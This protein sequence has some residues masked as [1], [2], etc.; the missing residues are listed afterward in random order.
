MRK[1]YKWQNVY[2]LKNE[3][4]FLILTLTKLGGQMIIKTDAC[5]KRVGQMLLKKWERGK[6]LVSR[7]LE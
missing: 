7:L 1:P 6:L 4:S 5:A 3:E 2:E